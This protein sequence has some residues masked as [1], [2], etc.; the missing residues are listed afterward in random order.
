M[1]TPSARPIPEVSPA[2]A[3]YFAAARAG[4]LVVQRC[5]GCGALRFPPRELC[6]VCLATEAAWQEVSGR[7]EIFSYYV[8]HQIYHPG[9]AAEVPYAVVVVKLEEGPKLTS[10]VVDCPLDEIAIGMPVEVVF[11]ELSPEV[12]LPKFRRRAR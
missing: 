12:T 11:E 3:P 7:G 10:N 9:F 1:S 6:S 5:T 2:L 4:R 8:M